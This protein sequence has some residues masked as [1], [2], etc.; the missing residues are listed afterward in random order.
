M[1]GENSMMSGGSFPNPTND[2]LQN[3]QL[4][5]AAPFLYAAHHS[6]SP[7]GPQVSAGTSPYATIPSFHPAPH[8]PT[9][10]PPNQPT[11]SLPFSQFMSYN[12]TDMQQAPTLS[13]PKHD[14]TKNLM[15]HPS[16]IN[17]PK[18]NATFN[19]INND[20]SKASTHIT[21]LIS[22]S[23]LLIN[24]QQPPQS[25]ISPLSTTTSTASLSNIWPYTTGGTPLNLTQ[26]AAQSAAATAVAAMG[27][28]NNENS[29]NTEIAQEILKE[30]TTPTK[31][32]K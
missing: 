18:P 6:H 14:I 9:I 2:H 22:S 24:S 15:Q 32:N 4:A 13:S 17:I 29:Q 11:Q 20:P 30:L 23:P 28:L 7:F 19:G 27:L 21:D 10:I 31:Q 26:R 1:N 5:A 25:L 16:V 8:P 12:P 3:A